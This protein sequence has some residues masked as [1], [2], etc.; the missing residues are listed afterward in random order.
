MTTSDKDWQRVTK[1]TMSDNEWQRM[2]KQ[3]N[4]NE[5]VKYSDVM[6][7]KKQKANLFPEYFYSIFYAIYNDYQKQPFADVFWNRCS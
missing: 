6:F 5:K 7:Q 1:M 4:S 3:M 2:I